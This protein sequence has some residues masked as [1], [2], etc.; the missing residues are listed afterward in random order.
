MKR[1]GVDWLLPGEAIRTIIA[2][3]EA[4]LPLLGFDGAYLLDET[5]QPSMDD[6]WDYSIQSCPTVPD[7]YTHA[8]QFI[9]ER[10]ETEL[11]FEIV[12]GRAVSS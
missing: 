1:G 3:Q 10:A 7:R 9:S 2:A 6:S 5:T 8:I 4:G 11:R 12:L